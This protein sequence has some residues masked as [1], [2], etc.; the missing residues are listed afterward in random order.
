MNVRRL[1]APSLGRRRLPLVSASNLRVAQIAH[2]ASFEGVRAFPS[3]EWVLLE[4]YRP[5]I[6]VGDTAD[7][8]QLAQRVKSSLIDLSSVD[9]A[10]FAL[11]YGGAEPLSDVMRVVLW[12]AFGVPVYELFIGRGGI[13]AAECETH[14]GWHV[15][16]GAAFRMDDGELLFDGFGARAVRTG[17]HASIETEPCPCGRT[18]PRITGVAVLRT[19]SRRL[20]AT[21]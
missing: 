7:L 18:T 5:R 10:V 1:S 12:Q 3:E 11:T 16:P 20:A 13:L 9:H 2:S 8:H 21:A 19:H 6:L 17:L 14:E 15:E 4:E